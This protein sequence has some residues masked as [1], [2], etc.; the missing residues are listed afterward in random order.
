MPDLTT[1]EGLSFLAIFHGGNMRKLESKFDS[2]MVI[3][4]LSHKSFFIEDGFLLDIE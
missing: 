3:G 2:K 4:V 1:S